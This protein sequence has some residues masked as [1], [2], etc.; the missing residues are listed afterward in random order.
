VT[1]KR[2]ANRPS[3]YDKAGGDE[4]VPVITL[5]LTL[6]GAT[7]EEIAAAFGVS[8]RSITNWK[9]RYPQFKQA[10]IEGKMLADAQ[11]GQRLFERAT[12]YEHPED[13][14]FYDSKTGETVV[15]P[16]TKHYP[17]DTVAAI[18]WLKNRRP[19]LWRDKQDINHGS[20]DGSMK[21]QVVLYQ[22]PDNGRG[23][24]N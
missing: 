3:E 4:K 12:G 2:P 22:L 7:E 15:A 21:P 5:Q 18:F 20:E 10:L 9:G 23:S 17:P 24:D 19:D 13:K 14:I 1:K 6:L 16:T 8:R 11:V